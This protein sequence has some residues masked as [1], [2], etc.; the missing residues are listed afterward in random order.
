[1]LAGIG[2]IGVLTAT[3]A[4]YFIG[5]KE[6]EAAKERTEIL[7]RLERIEAL[8]QGRGRAEITRMEPLDMDDTG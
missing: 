4:S 3:I 7:A 5:G 6:D 1:M 8:L 2:L